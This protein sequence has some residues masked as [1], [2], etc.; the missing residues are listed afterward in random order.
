MCIRDR[1]ATARTHANPLYATSAVLRGNQFPLPAWRPRSGRNI[2]YLQWHSEL[3]KL[4][5]AL[6]VTEDFIFSTPPAD[7]KHAEGIRTKAEVAARAAERDEW[8]AINTTIFWHV[9]PSLDISGVTWQRDTDYIATLYSKQLANGAMLIR[10][11]QSFADLS[12]KEAQYKLVDHVRSAQ[13]K[14]CLLYTSPSPRDLSTSRMPS[15]A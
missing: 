13:L 15:S 1:T 6:D 7:P 2:Q 5:A 11:A 9:L 10:W 8:L 4:Y 14:A 12:G 3:K